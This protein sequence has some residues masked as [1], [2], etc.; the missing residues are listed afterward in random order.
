METEDTPLP[1]AAEHHRVALLNLQAQARA[2]ALGRDEA[3]TAAE[4]RASG[5]PEERIAELLP[6]RTF[7]G[8]VPNSTLWLEALTRTAWARWSRSTS[9]RCSARPPSGAS[10]PTTS[11][12]SGSARRWRS[13]W[14]K[15][16]SDLAGQRCAQSQP[17]DQLGW[18]GVKN[19]KPADA[20][21]C[22]AEPEFWFARAR[23]GPLGYRPTSYQ[24]APPRV[25]N[26]IIARIIRL[27]GFCRNFCA[28]DQLDQ[29][30]RGVVADAE[31]HL[32]D[33]G[34]A[35]RTVGGTLAQVVEQLGDDVAVRRRSKARRRLATVSTLARV[36]MRSTTRR[37]SLALGTV[38]LM[39][40]CVSSEFIMLRSMA[41]RWAL[42][43]LSLRSPFP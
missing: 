25:K 5:L 41:W 4:L 40:S 36:I 43:R 32:Q 31:A 8:N 6:H 42:V 7:R 20:G 35:A 3:A 18:Q 2:L 28:V 37:S 12:A 15:T 29:G 27:P 30:H 9:T 17:S 38:V 24:A 34:V 33:A 26:L 10:T 11:G 39:T 13:G 23:F 16:G 19:K 21:F 14:R 22:L 1:L